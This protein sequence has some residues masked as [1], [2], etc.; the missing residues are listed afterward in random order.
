MQYRMDPLI[1]DYPSRRFYEGRLAAAPSV[2]ARAPP[3]FLMP[4][5][6]YMVIRVDSREMSAGPSFQNEKEVTAVYDLVKS[7]IEMNPSM[8]A[9]R[10]ILELFTYFKN[11]S[12]V[13]T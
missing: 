4:H 6:P 11:L 12:Q 2:V 13:S 3:A 7:F 1:C 9:L 5:G 8:I 10:G